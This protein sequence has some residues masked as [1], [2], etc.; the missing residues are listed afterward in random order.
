MDAY[1]LNVNL[2]GTYTQKYDVDVPALPG[3]VKQGV[4]GSVG[5]VTDDNDNAL[6]AAS[7]SGTNGVVSRWKH[8]LSVGLSRGVWNGTLTQNFQSGYRDAY[9]PATG[10]EHDIGS[11][12]TYD[13][14]V[15]YTGVKNLNVALGARNVFD[16]KPPFSFIGTVYNVFQSGWDP[17][18]YDPRG[19]FVYLNLGYKFF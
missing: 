17:S 12:S 6:T 18:Y 19:R 7:V 8:T 2:Q 14:Q 9:N 5:R 3:Q 1:T 4:Q 11:F 16:K 10:D 13:L 15:G